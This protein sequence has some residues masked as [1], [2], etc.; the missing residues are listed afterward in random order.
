MKKDLKY[1][2]NLDYEV[3]HRKLS[4]A[5]GGGYIAFI[6]LLGKYTFQADG[7]TIEEALDNLEKVKK[8]LFKDFLKKG[9][10]IPEPLREQDYSGKFIMRVPKFLHKNL[11]EEAKKNNTSLNQYVLTL[12]SRNSKVAEKQIIYSV[13]KKANKYV[14]KG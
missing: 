14:K 12:L 7:K 11:V 9:Y 8:E 2:M 10:E 5:E 6:P 3:V 13:S 1:Y 4:D